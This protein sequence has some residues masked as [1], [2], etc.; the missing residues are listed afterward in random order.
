M[1]SIRAGIFGCSY[2]PKK[3]DKSQ[4]SRKKVDHF[5][6]FVGKITNWFIVFICEH[7]RT[8][9]L[10]D[11]AVRSDQLLSPRQQR[12]VWRIAFNPPLTSVRIGAG[13]LKNRQPQEC[14][15]FERD[16]TLLIDQGGNAQVK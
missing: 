11:G 5:A 14:V 8:I 13:R 10:I 1:V 2:C 3:F 6:T 4:L 12:A 7:L 9:L 15:L 16:T